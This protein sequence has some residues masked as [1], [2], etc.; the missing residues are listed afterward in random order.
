MFKALN[1]LNVNSIIEI[2]L[3]IFIHKIKLKLMPRQIYNKHEES[4]FIY[5]QTQELKINLMLI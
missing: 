3:I 2:Q 1:W 4:H 5:M